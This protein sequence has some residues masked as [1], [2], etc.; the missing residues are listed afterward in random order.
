MSSV[1]ADEFFPFGLGFPWNIP[2]L[3]KLIH[4]IEFGVLGTLLFRSFQLSFPTRLSFFWIGASFLTAV[5][6]ALSD[7]WHQQW[8]A[9]RITSFYDFVADIAGVVVALLIA[10]NKKL[11]TAKMKR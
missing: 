11:G 9:G 3:D 1:P 10:Q 2:H 4:F 6:Y 8:V 7:E 5:V